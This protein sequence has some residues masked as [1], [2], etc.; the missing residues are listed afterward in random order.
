MKG[1]VAITEYMVLLLMIVM[2]SFF[3]LFMLFGFPLIGAGQSS[4]DTKQTA[5]M[6]V[7]KSIL[8]RP[9]LI[10]LQFSEG[11]VL[12]DSKLTAAE[13]EH[14]EKI[15]GLDWYAE[16]RSFRSRSECD[17]LN[18]WIKKNCLKEIAKT[19]NTVCTTENYPNCGVWVLCG[20]NEKARN[21]E[22]SVPVNVYRK[23]NDTIELGVLTVGVPLGA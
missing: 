7:L 3:A 18:P 21:A 19:E 23:L 11:S 6:F 8:S 16:V 4:Y 13:C 22:W 9:N 5:S 2:I 1:Q 12:D 14:L 20:E 17:G 15:Y 10:N